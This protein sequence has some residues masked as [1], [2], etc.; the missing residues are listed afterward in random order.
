MIFWAC[1]GGAANPVGPGTPTPTPTPAASQ[2]PTVS[3]IAAAPGNVGYGENSTITVAATTADDS[4][5]TYVYK[6]DHGSV[7][8]NQSQVVYFNDGKTSVEYDI[9][10]VTVSGS[11]GKSTESGI[12]LGLNGHTPPPG[13]APFPKDIPNP[14]P[15]PVPTPT[16]APRPT[17]TPEPSP[18]STPTPSNHAPTVSVSGGGS[19]HPDCSLSFTAS[20]SDPDKDK[21]TYSWSGSGSCSCSSSTASASCAVTSVGSCT[22]TVTVDDSHGHQVSANETGDGTNNAPSI[23]VQASVTVSPGQTNYTTFGLTDD[24]PDNSASCQVVGTAGGV[25]NTSCGTSPQRRVNF[26]APSCSVCSGTVTFEVTDK[27]G[28]TSTRATLTIF[29]N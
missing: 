24:D 11:S 20:A 16:P 3:N 29:T 5:I 18:T 9:V 22:A 10:H 19:C 21:L 26:K 7:T 27:W 2:A 25:S 17:P 12:A 4:A 8:G 23:S 13:A 14:Q 1:G 6:A 28:A 15:T